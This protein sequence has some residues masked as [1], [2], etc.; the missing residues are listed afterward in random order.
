MKPIWPKPFLYFGNVRLF[1]ISLCV[2]IALFLTGI[3]FALY[4]ETDDLIIQ[5]MHEQAINYADLLRHTKDWN[6]NYGGVYVE[7]R[8]G[9]ESNRYLLGLGIDPDVHTEHGRVFTM[10]NH[11]IMIDEIS[12]QIERHEGIRFRAVSLKPL[13]PANAPDPTEHAALLLFKNG[14][15]EFHRTATD[16]KGK[17]IYR[18]ILPLYVEGSCL[19]C[20]R[21]QGYHVGSVIGAI[22]ITIP[23]AGML[24]EMKANRKLII[25]SG[26]LTISLLVGIIYFL[27]W[28]L[29]IK[30]D[31][32]QN[33]LKMQAS[34]D[35]LTGLKNRRHIMK[36]LSEEFERAT[37]L[38]DSLCII[39]FD[40]DHFKRINDTYG[41]LC[42]DQVL[43]KV[44]L[45]MSD[46]L[47]RYDSIGRIGGEEF[48]VIMPEASIQDATVLAERLLQTVRSDQ[49]GD[50]TCSF[51]ITVSAGI[52]SLAAADK[53]VSSLIKRAD[54][55]LYKA[56][57]NGR[58][59]AEVI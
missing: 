12:R 41:H 48:L 46:N 29:V 35:E 3:F 1:L 6:Y 34:T 49:F 25:L 30:L 33:K 57:E 17:P 40:I 54:S 5:R 4:S 58:D 56:K 47:R 55:A 19:E 36:R 24:D 32:T 22:S 28:R 21:T 52:A 27:T 31:E 18:Y 51:A 59:R 42:G 23:I 38:N 16:E 14:T 53:N 9:V 39:I 26:I 37:R 11:A 15:K 8:P 2:I 10:R 20:H 13:S 44:A 50:G 7:K 43:K 45:Q